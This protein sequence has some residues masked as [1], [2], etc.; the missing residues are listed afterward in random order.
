[1][2]LELFQTMLF[3]FLLGSQRVLRL[4]GFYL[5]VKFMMAVY[6]LTELF[7]RLHQVRLDFFLCVPIHSGYSPLVE[8]PRRAAQEP[9]L[10]GG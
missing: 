6:K 9:L 7:I 1:M 5:R 3:Q 2:K 8:L 10:P 4:E